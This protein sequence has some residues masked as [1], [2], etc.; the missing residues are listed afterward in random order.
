MAELKV[1]IKECGFDQNIQQIVVKDKFIFGVTVYEIQELL[2]N[3][4]E[5]YHDL[6]YCL[7]EA[8]KN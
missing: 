2:L 6:N 5:D 8:H 1:L 3:D 4:I 7:Q